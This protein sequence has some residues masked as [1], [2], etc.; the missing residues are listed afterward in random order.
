MRFHRPL[1]A[2]V[3]IFFIGA[4]PALG[5]SAAGIIAT[6]SGEMSA[7]TWPVEDPAHAMDPFYA[8]LARTAA[9]RPGAVTRDVRSRYINDFHVR[10]PCLIRQ[11]DSPDST[12]S[13]AGDMGKAS[14]LLVKPEP[15]R[16]LKNDRSKPAKTVRVVNLDCCDEVC[17][18]AEERRL[19]FG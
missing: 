18:M 3:L 12:G 16:T 13:A 10:D 2:L 5:A 4:A 7:K 17:G 15:L 19:E 1:S 14:V 8:A 9:K 11:F 6:L